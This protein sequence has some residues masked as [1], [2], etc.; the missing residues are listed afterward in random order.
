[1]YYEAVI[2]DNDDTLVQT[3]TC[4]WAA[5][6]ETAKRF[7]SVTVTDA[8]IK[9]VWGNP[10]PEI[11]AEILHHIDTPQT[12]KTHYESIIGE[13]PKL[14]HP[15][16]VETVNWLLGLGVSVSVLT[17]SGKDIVINDLTALGFPIARLTMVQTAEDT[18]AH[19]P[20]PAVFIPILEKL[21]RQNIRKDQTIYIGDA[22]MDY[23][24][25]RG[26]GIHFCGITQGLTSI[27][28]FRQA[29][30]AAVTSFA[31]LRTYLSQT[32]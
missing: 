24:A 16:A 28:D 8:D 2:F 23:T 1:M 11:L 5:I 29:G 30:A 3:I 9:P 18:T 19:K 10:Y 17:A 25:A 31:D 14:A 4:R 6:K 32:P 20:D 7:Y 13:F 21:E 27:F 12:I 26:A 15:G 22:M